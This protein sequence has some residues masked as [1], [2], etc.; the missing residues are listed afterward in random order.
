[1]RF[2]KLIEASYKD[3]GKCCVA[4]EKTDCKIEC[5]IMVEI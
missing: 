5:I 3:G 2:L 1:M 4:N